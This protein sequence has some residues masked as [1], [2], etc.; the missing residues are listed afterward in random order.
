MEKSNTLTT[1]A[2]SATQSADDN[3]ETQ[4]Q[5]T[6]SAQ[7]QEGSLTPEQSEALEGARLEAEEEAQSN[8]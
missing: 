6:E 3:R 2:P 5:T 1:A 8:Q 7:S 4:T